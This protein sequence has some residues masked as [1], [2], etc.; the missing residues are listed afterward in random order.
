MAL[1]VYYDSGLMGHS[2]GNENF[3]WQRLSVDQYI[4]RLI[5]GPLFI[6]ALSIISEKAGKK[7]AQ[8]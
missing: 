7:Y 6:K 3:L 4:A 8:V 2:L 5:P 1:C